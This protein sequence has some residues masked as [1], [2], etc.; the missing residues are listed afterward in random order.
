MNQKSP[1]RRDRR[2]HNAHRAKN[3]KSNDQEYNSPGSHLR[4][5]TREQTTPGL[6]TSPELPECPVGD[7]TRQPRLRKNANINS[8]RKQNVIKNVDLTFDVPNERVDGYEVTKRSF[9][10]YQKK[11]HEGTSESEGEKVGA[12]KSS[13]STSYYSEG[14]TK[15]EMKPEAEVAQ[16]SKKLSFDGN[17]PQSKTDS[18]QI[19]ETETTSFRTQ[20]SRASNNRNSRKKQTR[21]LTA[22]S[23]V[24]S[25]RNNRPPRRNR[26]GVPSSSETRTFVCK[27]SKSTDNTAT[28]RSTAQFTSSTITTNEQNMQQQQFV[29][30]EAS[31]L[32]NRRRHAV[33][34]SCI[35]HDDGQVEVE[36]SGF[37]LMDPESV[38]RCWFS[39]GDKEGLFH[40]RYEDNDD[41][42]EKIA[43]SS[44]SKEAGG[45]S[46]EE[47]EEEK[48]EEEEEDITTNNNFGRNGWHRVLHGLHSPTD[49]TETGPENLKEKILPGTVDQLTAIHILQRDYP[50]LYEYDTV[51]EEYRCLS[52]EI[53][54]LEKDRRDLERKFNGIVNKHAKNCHS[55]RS[56]MGNLNFLRWKDLKS[57]PFTWLEDLALPSPHDDLTNVKRQTKFTSRKKS[58]ILPKSM[59]KS[60]RHQRGVGLA[61]LMADIGAKN[62]LIG[63]CYMNRGKAMSQRVMGKHPLL[64]V[65]GSTTFIR[66]GAQWVKYA[67]I[68]GRC[69]ATIND[70]SKIQ[71]GPSQNSSL[72]KGRQSL[73]STAAGTKYFLKFDGE[74]AHHRGPLPLRLE[75]R[76]SRERRDPRSLRYLSTG[77]SYT[78]DGISGD[79]CCYY[80]EFD[81]GECWWGTQNANG[82]EDEI[83][84]EILMEMDVHRVAFGNPTSPFAR[85][86]SWIVIGKDGSV[87]WRNIPQGLH[88]VLMERYELTRFSTPSSAIDDV[89]NRRSPVRKGSNVGVIRAE[90]AAPC[91]VS[92]GVA[93][94]YFVRFMDGAVDY[95]LPSF[96]ADVCEKLEAEGKVIRNVAL[97]SDTHD[98]LVRFSVKTGIR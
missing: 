26:M 97:H 82:E 31:E 11:E 86:S 66:N 71:H 83:L 80:A 23:N 84:H 38:Y 51:Q 78:D 93:G 63:R 67:G 85:K 36:S 46:T 47:E 88:D 72:S 60:L 13:N 98:C 91:E 12:P 53:N 94:T 56:M 48:E 43:V 89:P 9:R 54:A 42:S 10:S 20:N 55:Y 37:V 75:L 39:T 28:C 3:L 65:E 96:A 90:A 44:S 69:H 81:S 8:R 6:T 22:K 73:S 64:R 34:V 15:N 76:L 62:S 4:R 74:K 2:R 95:S 87:A 40:V 35:Y 30:R 77:S 41:E 19:N 32:Q 25:K 70:I 59:E 58:S 52:Q 16:S 27:Q 68:T 45:T 7:H 18:F 24:D 21:N 57:L 33:E 1:S 14:N 17:S 49:T 92:L 79:G 29:Q 61:I 50:Q 5:G